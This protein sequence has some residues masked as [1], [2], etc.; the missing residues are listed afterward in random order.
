MLIRGVPPHE[1]W[2][3]TDQRRQ[4]PRAAQHAGHSQSSH[5]NRI[6]EWSDD[7]VV[8]V[9]T[10][11]TQMED[12]GCGK[13]DVQGTPDVA[14][15]SAEVPTVCQFDR[16][17]EGHST[18]SHEEVCSR[19]ADHITICRYTKFP[20]APDAGDDQCVA[21]QRRH[22]N[23]DHHYAFYHRPDHVWLL[24]RVLRGAGRLQRIM[25]SCI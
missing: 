7:C 22:D 8:P 14:H 25:D 4:K 16:C 5:N 9:H 3:E 23:A 18:N 15:N 21:Y 19:Q 10:D 6:L 1:D 17:V 24:I 12:R 2:Y 13:I 20:M 11:A